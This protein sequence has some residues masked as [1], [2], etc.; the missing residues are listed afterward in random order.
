MPVHE[1]AIVAP[2]CVVPFDLSTPCEVFGRAR[3]ADGRPAYRVRVCGV[4]REVR[5]GPFDL[6]LRHGLPALRT[7]DT[8]VVAG[9]EDI[10]APVPAPLVRAL[11]RAHERGVRIASVCSGAFVLAA[12]G[13]LD[14]KRAT[15][16]W[17]AAHELARR[18]PAI[19]VDPAVLFVD[20]GALLT[21]AGAAA[22][23]DLCLHM[24][25]RD[26]GAAVAAETAR[27][28]VMPLER[29]GGQ[30]QF[31]THAPPGD[32]CSLEPMLEWMQENLQHALSLDVIAQA[33]GM[34]ARTL[35][36]RFREQTGTTPAQW[37]IT[38]R[39]RRAQHLL[40][41]SG[42]PIDRVGELA[43]FGSSSAFRSL[44][45]RVAGTSPR[46]YRR[47]FRGSDATAQATMPADRCAR[48]KP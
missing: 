9:S 31:I 34:S 21:S 20:A 38:A 8:I 10:D 32:G 13:L 19:D 24:V 30:A 4:A 12:T 18:H 25:R 41:T 44:F 1:L 43:G 29:A 45:A 46:A 48:S 37:L 33:F 14:G 3:L 11:R 28:S 42:Q 15:T 5:A 40:E 36:R 39:V 26:H 6:R 7:A 35:S 47:Q 2:P 17:L 16:H 27:L 22:A 23:F